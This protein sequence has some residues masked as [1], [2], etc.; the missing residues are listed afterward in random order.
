MTVHASSPS[1]IE[2]EN[3]AR[4]ISFQGAISLEGMK[5]LKETAIKE[6]P[7]NLVSH[8]EE[9]RYH[10]HDMEAFGLVPNCLTID[11]RRCFPINKLLAKDPPRR[12]IGIFDF[13]RQAIVAIAG[14]Q[15]GGVGFANFDDDIAWVC[16][17]LIIEDSKQSQQILRACIEGF[18]DWINNT[19]SRYGLECYYI[20]LNI[21]LSSAPLGRFVTKSL[22]EYFRDAPAD[23]IRPNIV[24]KTHYSLHLSEKALNRD[25]FE[26]ALTA[27]STRMI[28]TYLL[29]DSKPNKEIVPENLAIMGCRTRVAENING[30][31]TAIGRGNIAYISINLPRIA[32][33]SSYN[34]NLEQRIEV[35][36]EGWRSIAND[37][38]A[39][40]L[41]RKKLLEKRPAYFFPGYCTIDPWMEPFVE[42]EKVT[43]WRHA[44][45]SIGFVGLAEAVEIMTEERIGISPVANMIALN[46]VSTI[47]E[48]I[49]RMRAELQCNLTLL[50]TSAESTAGRFARLDWNNFRIPMAEKG[51]YT[52]SFHVPV[53][54]ELNPVQK[55]KI[56]GPFH[57]L[58]NGGCISYAEL[59]APPLG[60]I[61]AIEDMLRAARSAGVSYFGINF[62]LDVCYE[63]GNRGVFDT[64]SLC[65]SSSIAHFRRVSGYLEDLRA[66]T[67]GK[68]AEVSKRV[69]HVR[70][71]KP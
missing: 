26:A 15:S 57:S 61:S 46:L 20:T 64:C 52:N 10:I 58:C 1:A 13:I 51:F 38:A 30:E 2:N 19:R 21:G 36:I 25:C 27:T 70:G 47:R 31:T 53:D 71:G 65:G 34:G 33:I 50:A 48:D 28:P 17:Q 11:F 60:N 24:F 37:A 9:G 45:L 54:I 4:R 68:Q 41:K 7:P 35:F 69:A 39:L 56:E 8:H 44:T 43:V 14:D 49:D 18:V 67:P 3:A 42:S 23:Y 12:L 29:C 62:P 22:L 55:V 66:F 5:K 6:L 16:E 63:C 59:S 40:L 32:W